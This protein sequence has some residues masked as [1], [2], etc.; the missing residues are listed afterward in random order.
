MKLT[1]IP[2]PTTPM[3]RDDFDRFFDQFARVGLF[4][5]P[6]VTGETMWTPSL[7]FSE[8]EKE[9]VTRVEVPGMAKEDLDINVD[10]RLLTIS[11]HREFQK[12]EKTEEYYCQEREQGKFL[13]TLQLPAAVDS[14]K[15]GA[16]YDNGVLTVRLPK[17]EPTVKS[18]IAIR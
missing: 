2:R 12:E 8:T 18:R 5:L 10:G 16:T 7:D 3:I 4:G 14:T 1:T 17:M 9:F 13:R 6:A 15:V 11:G